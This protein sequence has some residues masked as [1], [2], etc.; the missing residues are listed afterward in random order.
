M[1]SL[2]LCTVVWIYFMH[3]IASCNTL[4]ANNFRRFLLLLLLLFLL[5]FSFSFFIILKSG[6]R[7]LLIRPR[8]DVRS[9]HRKP[10]ERWCKS[11]ENVQKNTTLRNTG[12]SHS[13]V[14]VVWMTMMVYMTCN[15]LLW[16]LI[17]RLDYC[18][19]ACLYSLRTEDVE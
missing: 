13:I 3:F 12:Q 4:K 8:N 5:F 18:W 10:E 11:I 14:R 2:S 6:R 7:P 17:D 19:I 15:L 9:M 1:R 16:Q